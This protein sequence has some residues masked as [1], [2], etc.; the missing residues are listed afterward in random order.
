M[1]L[2][3]SVKMNIQA[4]HKELSF[5]NSRSSGSGGQ[6]VNKV[7]TRVELCFPLKDSQ[8]LNDAQKT[9][10]SLRLAR[11][12]TKDGRLLIFSQRFR[13]QLMNRKAAIAQFDELILKNLQP[14]KKRKKLKT[15]QAEKEKRLKSKRHTIPKEKSS[16]KGLYL[17]F[18]FL[19]PYKCKYSYL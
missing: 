8:V 5:R 3:Y 1:D 2:A 10:L 17:K 12:L 11:R 19:F 14:E 4:L 6:H 7:E 15:P 13:S 9:L 16:K 18:P